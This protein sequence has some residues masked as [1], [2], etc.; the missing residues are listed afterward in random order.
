MIKFVINNNTKI[1]NLDYRQCLDCKNANSQIGYLTTGDCHATANAVSR[2]DNGENLPYRLLCHC[3][4]AKRVKQSP[5]FRLQKCKFTNR[6]SIIGDCHDCF[7]V[8]Q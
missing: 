3:E 8:S 7:A 6:K 5:V 2:N 4:R 1:A